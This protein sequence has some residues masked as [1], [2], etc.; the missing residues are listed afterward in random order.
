MRAIKSQRWS[1][2][3]EDYQRTDELS[4][5]TED[6]LTILLRILSMFKKPVLPSFIYETRQRMSG[7]RLSQSE[8]TLQRVVELFG[9]LL[10][11]LDEAGVTHTSRDV[12]RYCELEN[13]SYLVLRYVNTG[14]G[15]FEEWAEE[16]LHEGE[17]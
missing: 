16:L 8:Y 9:Q 1:K 12:L 7:R 5:N 15:P 10:I 13:I 3:L 14:A 6:D 2:E 17:V 4:E 11:Q